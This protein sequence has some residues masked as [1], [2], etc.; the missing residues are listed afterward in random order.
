MWAKICG[1]RATHG[2]ISNT[3]K[4]ARALQR[5]EKKLSNFNE[6]ND[7]IVHIYL[8]CLVGN[9]IAIIYSMITIASII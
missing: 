1:R 2:H 9:L 5:E 7:L 4:F 8:L 3:S 6:K